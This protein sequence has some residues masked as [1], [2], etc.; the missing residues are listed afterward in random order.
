MKKSLTVT[1][2]SQ[3]LHLELVVQSFVDAGRKLR[4]SARAKMRLSQ[5]QFDRYCDFA[6]V[7][8]S[9]LAEARQLSSWTN[10][11]ELAVR[12]LFFQKFLV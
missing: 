5:E 10:E 7:Y 2:E 8:A 4:S 11:K 9:V 6:C 1:V 12:K 3:V